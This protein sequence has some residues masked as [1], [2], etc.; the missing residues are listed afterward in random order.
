MRRALWGVLLSLCLACPG[1]VTGV[2]PEGPEAKAR[3][4]FEEGKALHEKGDYETSRLRLKEALKENP[5]LGAAYTLLGRQA[6]AEGKLEEAR[7]SFTRALELSQSDPEAALGLGQ[8]LTQMGEL[9]EAER[10]L[11]EAKRLALESPR[12]YY[13]LGELYAQGE[14]FDLAEAAYRE[15]IRFDPGYAWPR[16]GLARLLRQ[17]DPEKHHEEAVLLVK[18]AAQADATL[19]EA[20]HL[21]G[22]LYSDAKDYN[23]A[24]QSFRKAL[25]LNPKSPR[26]HMNLGSVIA[27]SG[28]DDT[29]T[30]EEERLKEA[31]SQL[32]EAITLDPG[33][34]LAYNNL[35]HILTKAGRIEEALPYLEKA[36]SLIPDAA[37]YQ[38]NLGDALSI[39]GRY[40][41]AAGA[42]RAALTLVPDQGSIA[43][44][45][46]D[47]LSKAGDLP[48]A[49]RVLADF[50]LA[51]PDDKAVP[52]LRDMMTQLAHEELKAQLR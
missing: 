9:S 13:F 32:K 52:A 51:Y 47:A 23:A 4:L 31:I 16:L 27:L 40:Q 15:S 20:H 45:L 22:L 5:N 25:E 6:L 7:N 39:M 10:W 17:K 28:K 48:G 36:V 43:R 38:I 14:Q 46:S 18:E 50:T 44:K 26:H 12:I 11:L 29:E 1:K 24:E 21:L 41:D 37:L 49:Y 8:T 30:L 2:L 33:Y 35:G 19:D 3:R 42:Y 34:A